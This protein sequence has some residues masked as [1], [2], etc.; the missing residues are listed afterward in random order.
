MRCDRRH[1]HVGCVRHRHIRIVDAMKKETRGG[2][3]IRLVRR[4]MTGTIRDILASDDT[5]LIGRNFLIVTPVN[6]RH[7]DI[8]VIHVTA[9]NINIVRGM[10]TNNNLDI[11]ELT[12]EEG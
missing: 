1:A 7:S 3:A 11:Y 5:E 12:T 10:A 2:S 9:D 8:N 4:R 6:D